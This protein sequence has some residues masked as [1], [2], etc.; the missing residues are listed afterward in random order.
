CTTVEFFNALLRF[1]ARRGYPSQI[2]SDNAAQFHLTHIL[3]DKAW[4]KVPDDPTVVSHLAKQGIKWSFIVELAPWQGGHYERLVGVVKSILKTMVG[5]RLL[6]WSDFVTLLIETESIVNSRPITYVN[7][8]VDEGFCVL[9]PMDFLLFRPIN[10]PPT[11]PSDFPIRDLGD[12]GKR[13]AS[14]WKQ[15]ERHLA[16]LWSVWHEQYLLSL[17]ERANIF[18]KPRR[19][20]IDRAPTVGEVVIVKDEGVPRGAWKLARILKLIE[21]KDKKI[22][23]AEVQLSNGIHLNRAIN[24]LIP[25]EITPTQTETHNDTPNASDYSNNN[26]LSNPNDEQFFGF[27]HSD[28]MRTAQM[29]DMYRDTDS[30]S[31]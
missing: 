16:K 2:I 28:V 4:K 26:E 9:R 7:S 27:S 19:N 20:R 5:R 11:V 25:L 22:R 29:L 17:R 8:D 13:L 31:E 6:T 10:S 3:A 1:M 18:H 12:S 23:A 14:I 15:R 21:S 30:D 24:F